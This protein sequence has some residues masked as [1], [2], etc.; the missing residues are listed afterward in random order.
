MSEYLRTNQEKSVDIRK[1]MVLQFK[2]KLKIVYLLLFTMQKPVTS[3]TLRLR[4]KVAQNMINMP[5]KS[6]MN[7]ATIVTM[8]S[9]F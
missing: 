6:N 8:Q 1:N 7:G 9:T 2:K 3:L 5:P 4:S